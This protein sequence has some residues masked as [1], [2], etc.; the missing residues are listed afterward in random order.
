MTIN[1]R[2]KSEP[3]T[4]LWRARRK[5]GLERKQSAWLLGHRTPDTIARYERGETEPSLDNAV[6][7]SIAYGCGLEKLFPL[8]YESFRR[9]L[10]TKAL[11]IRMQPTDARH[12][13][14]ARINV[15]SYEDALR[16]PE[17]SAEYFPHVRDHVTRLA[18]RLA[19]L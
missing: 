8:K 4:A 10:A 3:N 17:R 19:G 15:C 18:K 14:F 6:K 11:S 7:L 13:L 1:K 5:T 9:E 12:D 2:N 16:D